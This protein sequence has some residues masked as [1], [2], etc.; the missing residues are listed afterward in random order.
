MSSVINFNA[1]PS[2]LPHPVLEQVQ[3]ELL[4]YRG[5][6]MSI[7]EMSHRSPEYEAINNRAEANFKRLLGIGEGYRVKEK[8][9]RYNALDAVRAAAVIK[10]CKGEGARWKERQV[11]GAI[12]RLESR[13]VRGRIIEG[14]PRI[15]GS[16]RNMNTMPTATQAKTT[17][18]TGQPWRCRNPEN[19]T[20]SAPRSTA[21]R[22][23]MTMSR[24]W[25]MRKMTT[26]ITPPT[27]S[28]R[29]DQG[30]WRP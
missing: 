20:S 3:A 25:M 7:M 29:H 12:E 11:L 30:G 27:S 14:E 13:I 8:M 2:M 9:A 5:R 6:G 18:T 4:D 26:A 16:V 19:G 10:L 24:S 21:T 17:R 15:D 1:G 23:G 22:T 28:S